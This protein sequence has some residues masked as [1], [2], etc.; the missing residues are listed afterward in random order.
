MSRAKRACSMRRVFVGLFRLECCCG[1]S[2]GGGGG[3]CVALLGLAFF[4]TLYGAV[5]VGKSRDAARYVGLF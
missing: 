4:V 3:M 2:G 5:K 1:G